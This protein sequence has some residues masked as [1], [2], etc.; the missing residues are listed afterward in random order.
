MSCWIDLRNIS[1]YWNFLSFPIW[2]G[3]GSW[4]S[5]SWDLF[6]PI[7]STMSADDLA[8]Q[9]FCATHP[10]DQQC[11]CWVLIHLTIVCFLNF[12]DIIQH[13]NMQ[14]LLIIIRSF[15]FINISLTAQKTYI[16][17]GS[18]AYDWYLQTIPTSTIFR[19]IKRLLTI[20]CVEVPLNIFHHLQY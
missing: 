19:H 12:L 9:L 1:T 6:T 18:A 4:N 13:N 15:M 2:D 17:C 5:S 8:T 11:I 16:C 7:V 3:T 14:L 20:P 10:G